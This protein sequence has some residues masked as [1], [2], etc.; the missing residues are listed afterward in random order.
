MPT[1]NTFYLIFFAYYLLKVHC[2]QS[3]RFP[4]TVGIKAFLNLLLA[5]ERIRI[6]DPQIITDP[7]SPETYRSYRSGSGTLIATYYCNTYTASVCCTV[8]RIL[9][10]VMPWLSRFF[11]SQHGCFVFNSKGRNGTVTPCSYILSG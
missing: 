10:T 4:T 8:Y 1:K 6:P 2:H 9:N 5:D 11:R 3:L 7:G